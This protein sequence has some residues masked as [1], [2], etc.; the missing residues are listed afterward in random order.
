MEAFRLSVQILQFMHSSPVCMLDFISATT[1]G[2][3][4][5]IEAWTIGAI[6]GSGGNFEN[7]IVDF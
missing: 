1:T 5:H 7:L 4:A 2:Y 6:Y 3:K